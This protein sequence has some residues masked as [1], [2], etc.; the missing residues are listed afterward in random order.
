MKKSIANRYWIGIAAAVWLSSS[1]GWIT[2]QE[3]TD[4]Q[5]DDFQVLFDGSSLDAWRGYRQTR[6]GRGWRIDDG[7]LHFDGSGGGDIVTKSEFGDFELVFEWRVASGANSGVMYR[8]SLGD[9]APYLTGPEYQILDDD[10]H[11]D[12]RNPST[13]A[14][15][16]YALYAPENKTLKPVGAW[17][18]A[19]IVVVGHQVEHWLNGVKVVSCVIG[20]DD[21]NDRVAKSKF[22][23]WTKFAQNARGHICF[24]DHGDQVWFRNIRVREIASEK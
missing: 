23:Q 4:K 2:G 22:S 12:G 9:Q 7:A 5:S 11:A 18:E 21:W 20:S 24:Q 19:R 15:S 8:V 14:G 3:T 6:I 10:N 17:N 1:G 13:S 16:L